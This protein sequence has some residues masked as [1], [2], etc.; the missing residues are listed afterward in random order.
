M[1]GRRS[2]ISPAPRRA[3]ARNGGTAS[4]GCAAASLGTAARGLLSPYL[5]I[6][7]ALN[8]AG[9]LRVY[10]G[11]PAI[12]QALLRSQDRLLACEMEPQAAAALTRNL[13]ADR[14]SK[15]IA[16]DGWTA[17]NAFIPP[18]ERRGLVLIDPPY[19]DPAEFMRL[20][21][22]LEAAYRKWPGGSYLVWYPIKQRG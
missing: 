4:G 17:L 16:I 13:A 12:V 22:A 20:A 8:P 19:E 21:Q 10:P 18:K 7:A 3:A 1:R 14:R 9:A 5:D 15:A 6:V 2:T 11:S